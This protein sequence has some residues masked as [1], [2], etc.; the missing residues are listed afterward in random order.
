MTYESEMFSTA[1]KVVNR[2]LPHDGLM[3][4][5]DGYEHTADDA[6][7]AP[8]TSSTPRLEDHAEGISRLVRLGASEIFARLEPIPFLLEGLDMCPGA[9]AMIAGYGY[10]GKTVAAQDLALA[11]ASGQRA[12]GTFSVRKGSVLHVDFEQGARLTRERYQRLAQARMLTPNE[13]TSLALVA[14]PPTYLD[15][16]GAADL[17]SR[18]C[19]GVALV[20]FDSL[21]AAA[22]SLEENDS[23]VR[24]TLDLLGRVSEKT[25]ATILVLHHA[26]KPSQDRS[27]G[28]RMAIR[29]SGALYD[30]CS[31]V[32]VFEGEKG[33]P[34]RC[35][36]EK[37]RTT[38]R[39]AS[40]FLLRVANVDVDGDPRGGLS[41]TAEAVSETPDGA[42]ARRNLDAVKDR[43]RAYLREHGYSTGK[44]HI[45]KALGG[46][47]TALWAAFDELEADSELVGTKTGRT[48]R[49]ELRKTEAER[50]IK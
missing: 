5:D 29:G 42:K 22:P 2:A 3:P 27:G 16:A 37:A 36:H 43:V 41:V 12:W 6:P 47:R 31:S 39:T 15:T 9:P 34:T 23:G 35:Y 28:A 7:D 48:Y 26:R 19:E 14:M 30:A 4:P 13:L 46:D 33:G 21:R 45:A 49:Y 8:P 40:D 18:E 11:V 1:R 10:S 17:W 38:G 24:R 20:I 32:L 25:G 50:G 44:S